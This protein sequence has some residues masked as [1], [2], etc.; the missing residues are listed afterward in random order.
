MKRTYIL[1]PA[2]LA[3]IVTGCAETAS[4][5]PTVSPAPTQVPA[6]PSPVPTQATGE[7]DTPLADLVPDELNGVARTDIPGMEAFL[8]PA[9][10]EMGADV[11]EVEFIITTY[12]EGPDSVALNAL[13]IP[14]MDDVSM[15]MLAA[16]LAGSEAGGEVD[17]EAITIGGKSVLRLTAPEA[18]GGTVYMY[19]AEGAIF[20]IV[21][22]SAD[23]AQQLLA[24]LP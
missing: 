7:F 22:E 21:S 24:E 9:L 6:T 13:R 15:Q 14:G 19:F 16:M 20:T 17:A 12:G 3:L 11:G 23:L 1:V 4:P 18:G 10:A 2:L 8:G 5:T